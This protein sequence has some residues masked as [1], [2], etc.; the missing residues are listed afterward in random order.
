MLIQS[1]CILLLTKKQANEQKPS[2]NK[3]WQDVMRQ[4]ENV[5]LFTNIKLY[6]Y[7]IPDIKGL[8]NTSSQIRSSR[9]NV[10]CKKGVL[11][12][13]AKFTGQ[14]L[15]QSLCFSLCFCQIVYLLPIATLLFTLGHIF[16]YLLPLTGP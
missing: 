5:R 11:R 3:Y 8:E 6:L 1:Q 15:W 12:N 7:G 10:F 16:D 14:H 13:F 2:S 9:P 4:Y